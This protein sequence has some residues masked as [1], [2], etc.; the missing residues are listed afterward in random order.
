MN[1]L[2]ATG[3]IG[4]LTMVSRVLGFAREMIFARIM[5]AG[6][7]ADA[8]A[9]AFIIPNL[10][11][12]L[13]G[14]GAFSQGFVPLFSQR[15]QNSEEEARRFAEEVLAVFLPFLMLITAVFMVFMPAFIALIGAGWTDEPTKFGLAIDLTRITMPYL[16]FICL[17]S[18][19]S[20]VLNS[21]ARFTAAAFAPS[22]L[23]IALIAA[24]L[25][26]PTG[27]PTTARSMAWAVVAGGVLQ[28]ALCW[29]AAHRAGVKLRIRRPRL[30]PGVKEM[31]VLV[32]PATLGGGIYYISQAFYAYFATSLP[33]GSLVYL[34]FADR[35]NQLPLAII[36]SAL[37][38]AILPAISRA[39]GNND[40]AA[41]ASVQS[42]AVELSMLLTLPAAIAL[43]V[44]S[45][46]IV[47]ALF[48]GG[49]FTAEDAATTALVLSIIA[50][51]LPAYVLIK[52]LTPGFYA[53]RDVKTPVAI[54]VV[55]LIVGVGLN[56]V[57][58]PVM[59][60]S[61]LAFTTALSAWL[62]AFALY[63]LL[64][65]RGHFKL[66]G[67][68][69]SRLLR[70]IIAAVAMGAAIWFVGDLLSGFFAGSTGRRLIAVA[71]IVGTGGIVY[72]ALGWLIGA[73]NKEE[74]L[75]LLRK[76]KVQP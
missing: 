12:R 69:W 1:L 33:Q 14:E 37:G 39:I 57:L 59:G 76:K 30:T 22:L 15:H 49:R 24:L 63:V 20:G 18:L 44:A 10:F 7:A 29:V 4:G 16:V 47:A 48:Q 31:V 23:N 41:A 3:T 36:G 35:L 61:A 40:P 68:L 11:R 58:V 21:L 54:A 5:G 72:F 13:F 8:F 25:L 62:N 52:V 9:L 50:A 45:G 51:G 26:V 42:Q 28:L 60:I 67:W 27:G 73:I 43:S 6:M 17:V 74:V 38:T 65:R 34:G 53:R 32:L 75:I 55:M 66:Q 70:Q 64:A 2:K 71:A 19:F 56:F 46:P